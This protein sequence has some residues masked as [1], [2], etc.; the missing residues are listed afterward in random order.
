MKIS[1]AI[2]PEPLR[3]EGYDPLGDQLDRITKCL[4]HLAQ[5]GVDIGEFGLAQVAHSEQVK[6]RFP[7]KTVFN[8]GDQ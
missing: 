6:Q 4:S 7:K 2:N 3:A 5:N 8:D 1:K